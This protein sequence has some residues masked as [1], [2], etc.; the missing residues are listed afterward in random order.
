M[1]SAK[2]NGTWYKGLG[3]L[4]DNYI[5]RFLAI[6]VAWVGRLPIETADDRLEKIY[7]RNLE[8]ETSRGGIQLAVGNRDQGGNTDLESSSL[9]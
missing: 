5:R 9:V 6:A 4:S 1:L 2:V 7:G 3:K 8:F